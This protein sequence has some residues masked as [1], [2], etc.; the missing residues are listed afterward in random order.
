M[1]NGMKKTSEW[2]VASSKLL[3]LVAAGFLLPVFAMAEELTDPTRPP[4]S[5]SA[6]VAQAGVEVAEKSASLQ[7]IL[8]G[9][10]RRAAIIDGK[11]VELGSKVGAARLIEVNE[12]YVVLRT[13]QGRQVLT[14][15]PD[16]KITSVTLKK[17]RSGEKK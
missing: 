8:I 2:Q 5:I 16:V 11:T 6:P 12:A 7:S 1:A 3:Q 17:V 9:K 10:N 15:F 13:A 14:L 4:V